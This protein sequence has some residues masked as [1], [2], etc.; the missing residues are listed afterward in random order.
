MEDLVSFLIKS[1]VSYPDEVKLDVV[2]ESDKITVIKV[3][4]NP[5]D[6]GKVIGKFGKVASAIRTIVKSASGKSG[7]KYIVKIQ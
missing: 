4:V 3:S 7:K 1:I 2:N 6:V 5:Q